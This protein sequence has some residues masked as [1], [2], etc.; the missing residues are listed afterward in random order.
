MTTLGQAIANTTT[1][2]NGAPTFKSS[3][4]AVVDLFY[5]VGSM[6]NCSDEEI[7]SLVSAALNQ[8]AYLTGKVLLW[9]R[10]CRGGAGER[11]VFHVGMQVIDLEQA[12]KMIKRMSDVG[13]WKDVVEYTKYDATFDAAISE[14]KSGLL[15]G[16]SE[17]GLVCKW[18]PRK[19]PLAAK[20]RG[21]L[22]MSPKAY[23][24]MLVNGSKTV[25]QQMCAKQWAE[26]KYEHVPSVA[27]KKYNKAFLRNDTSRFAE[28]LQAAAKGEVKLNSGQLFPYEI[29][30]EV[31]GGSWYGYG[32]RDM[33]KV[34]RD[35]LNSQWK[36][37][38]N[39]MEGSKENIITVV[40]VS[41]SMSTPVAGHV[42][43][44]DVSVSLGLYTAL[45]S[46]GY[47][48]NKMITFSANPTWID[49]K[50][51]DVV[52]AVEQVRAA[53]WGMNTNLSKTYRMIL[54]AAVAHNLP[55]SELPTTILI[56][57]DMQFDYA[58]SGKT[59]LDDMKDEYTKAGYTMPKV[60]FWNV[61]GSGRGVP[62]KA[63]AEN[64]GLVSGFSP[65]NF[66][67]ILSGKEFTPRAIM[68]QT[69]DTP[70]Y[71]Y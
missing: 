62:A 3:T 16:E 51:T 18:L 57:S 11:R 27:M 1:T 26:I 71:D 56:V 34:D 24:K 21:G 39:Y 20:I 45:N 28:Y 59:A 8:D 53:E 6:R 42:S 35:L 29:V 37:L 19:G 54:D 36:N 5:K 55:E 52:N 30:S 14:I 65:S 47:F 13:T 66:K 49:L 48:K 58:V 31:P 17:S 67:A 9:A 4:D 23:R 12:K 64:V 40:D 25:E 44:M 68:L 50:T 70:R 10:D 41:G 33:S 32:R 43:A 38:P 46:E 15:N 63:D 7:Q 60:V 69:V 2:W 22:G 61:N